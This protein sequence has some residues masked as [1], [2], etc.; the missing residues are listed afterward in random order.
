MWGRVSEIN[1]FTDQPTENTFICVNTALEER[2]VSQESWH[3]SHIAPVRLSRQQPF[4]SIVFSGCSDSLSHRQQRALN[5][6]MTWTSDSPGLVPKAVTQIRRPLSSGFWRPTVDARR[7]L[8]RR[9]VIR[10]GRQSTALAVWSSISGGL[11]L[12]Q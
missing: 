1:I 5:S 10:D 11:N 7:P 4:V 6:H 2:D 8:P 3:P 9:R 12:D